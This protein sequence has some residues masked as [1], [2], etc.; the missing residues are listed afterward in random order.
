LHAAILGAR[1]FV[2]I[3]RILERE[4][5]ANPIIIPGPVIVNEESSIIVNIR[6]PSVTHSN[7]G[8]TVY[9]VNLFSFVRELPY[10]VTLS[11]TKND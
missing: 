10:G 11:R 6:E 8:G 3:T 5:S 9:L 2:K 4:D 7:S 1:E